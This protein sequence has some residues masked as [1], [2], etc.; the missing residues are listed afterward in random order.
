VVDAI[1]E[2]NRICRGILSWVVLVYFSLR[3]VKNK[4][5]LLL[6]SPT[7]IIGQWELGLSDLGCHVVDSIPE[8]GCLYSSTLAQAN[9]THKVQECCKAAA[10]STSL[11]IWRPLG[12]IPCQF[13]PSQQISWSPVLK[14]P[15]YFIL[16]RPSGSL[17][18][19]SA[20][21]LIPLPI[22]CAL[23]AF[24]INNMKIWTCL[25]SFVDISSLKVGEHMAVQSFSV[26]RL[27]NLCLLLTYMINTIR[28][29]YLYHKDKVVP[30]LN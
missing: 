10:N 13:R 16:C 30:M 12:P 24:F 29:S 17:Y 4:N 18:I 26:T 2:I 19:Y 3:K 9:T 20:F 7:A 23:P 6:S 1:Y 22:H 21:R 25:F 28:V 8:H 27:K 14:L 11:R 15:P 5:K